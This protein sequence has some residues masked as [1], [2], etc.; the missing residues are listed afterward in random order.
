M[1]ERTVFSVLVKLALMGKTLEVGIYIILH[2]YYIISI[3]LY[4]VH[5]VHV[6]NVKGTKVTNNYEYP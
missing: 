6:T 1:W 4:T 5:G 3:P 2:V